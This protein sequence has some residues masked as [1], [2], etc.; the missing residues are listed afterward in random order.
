M[1]EAI[2]NR[3]PELM[4]VNIAFYAMALITCI[5]RCYVRRF[6]VDA[7]RTDD[8][9]MVVSTIFFTLYATFSTVGT[10]FGTGR[11]HADL[12]TD[13]VTTAM[14]CWWFCYLWYCLTMISCKLSIGYFLLRVTT[15]KV[16]KWIIYLAM[17]S[18]ALSGIIFF[19]VTVFQCHPV[20]YF[21]NKEQ[22]GTCINPTVVIALAV[23][24]SVFAVGS[25]FIFAILPGFIV[26]K[27]Q[28]HKKTKYSLIPLLA[29]GC[30]ASAAVIAR[31]P[32]LPLIRSPDFLWNTTDIAIWSTIEQS[33]AITASSMA[34]LR[35]LIKQAAFR[36]GL[37]S[38]PVSIGPS[39][40]KNSSR[41]PGPGTPK[42]FS[43][44]DAYTLSSVSRT[45]NEKRGT[46]FF[47]SDLET[48]IKKEIKWEVKISRTVASESQEE[49]HTPRSVMNRNVI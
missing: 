2:D 6:V 10:T 44:R 37:T 27:L 39:G 28:L 33:L 18:T 41:T 38:K 7:F 25:D 40:Y 15:E 42:A 19:F 47:P 32:Y 20:S 31:F 43:G 26:W 3:G 36:L 24:Y 45:A 13:Q 21:W 23:L 16:Q 4:G 1:A 30:V 17:F 35:P 11:H 46:S 12:E 34:T 49:L 48:G 5:L 22:D 9:L 29:M 14:M 8:W